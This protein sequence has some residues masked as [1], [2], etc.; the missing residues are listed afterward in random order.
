MG[1]LTFNGFKTEKLPHPLGVPMNVKSPRVWGQTSKMSIFLVYRL[2][3]T[4]KVKQMVTSHFIP[5]PFRTSHFVPHLKSLCTNLKFTSYH[6][7]PHC[8]TII[9][10]SWNLLIRDQPGSQ[11]HQLCFTLQPL[12][13]HRRAAGSVH[14]RS[15]GDLGATLPR[16]CWF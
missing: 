5:R 15:C 11:I 4:L 3:Q 9:S 12:Q 10:D 7:V 16:H 2:C 1:K 14:G 8:T 6:N 13:G